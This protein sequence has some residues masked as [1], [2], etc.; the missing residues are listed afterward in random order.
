MEAVFESRDDALTSSNIVVLSYW[1]GDVAGALPLFMEEVEKALAK[2]QLARA[3]RTQ[4]FVAFSHAG[5]GRFDEMRDAMEQTEA[6]AARL[7]MPVPSI[8]QAKEI[9]ATATDEGL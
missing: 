2:G 5:L 6:L 9:I 7:G 3:A 1:Y 8:L 4:A